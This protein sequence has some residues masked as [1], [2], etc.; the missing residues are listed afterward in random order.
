LIHLELAK[1]ARTI[2]EYICNLRKGE[3]VL[4]YADTAA[5][6]VV[7]KHIAE[8]AHA[9]G[10]T[11]SLVLYE[12]RPEVDLEPPAPLAAAMKEA[13]LIIEL[14]EKYLIHTKAYLEALKT[15]RILCLTGM[16]QEMMKRCIADVDYPEMLAFGDALVGVLRRGNRMEI[17]TPAGTDLRFELGGRLVE[18]N[19]GR[20]FK[21]G[22]ESFLGGQASWYPLERTIN[23]TIV[24]DGSI[25]PPEDLGLLK[26]PVRLEIKGG[27]IKEIK[28]GPEAK[29][30]RSWLESFDDPKMFRIA[31]FSYGFNPGA[32]LSGKILEDERVFGCIEVGIGSQVPSFE[33]GP[34]SAHT[35]GIMLNPT[36]V[37]DGEVIEEEGRFIHP[38][39]AKRADSLLKARKER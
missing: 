29:R 16:T 18:H 12:T 14:A 35:D 19:A 4:I 27:E 5:D 36:L 37:L 9:A 33:V 11:V 21:P 28:G 38:E 15:A 26:Q 2:V 31:H 24:F 20:I 6:L 13:A 22:E 34:A 8:A 23:G 32:R 1:A 17:K 10:G 25:W 3:E 7:A 30:F 39:L